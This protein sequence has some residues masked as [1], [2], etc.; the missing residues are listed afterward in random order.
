MPREGRQRQLAE[1]DAVDFDAYSS[2]TPAGFADLGKTDDGKL[3]AMTGIGAAL[4]MAVASD[5][6]GELDRQ[7]IAVIGDG[8]M[9]GASVHRSLVFDH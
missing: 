4:G 6:K 7:H 3:V 2:Q 1:D 8:A 9:T 5:Y